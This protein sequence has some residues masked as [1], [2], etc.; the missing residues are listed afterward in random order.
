MKQEDKKYEYATAMFAIGMK[1]VWHIFIVG[2]SV[3]MAIKHSLW[4]LLLLLLLV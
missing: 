2:L 1:Y 4:W 3:C